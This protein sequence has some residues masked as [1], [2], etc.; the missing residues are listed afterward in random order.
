MRKWVSR[1]FNVI[2][3]SEMLNSKLTDAEANRQGFL[4]TSNEEFLRQYYYADTQ[5]DSIFTV[6]KKLTSSN[7]KQKVLTDSL[8]PLLSLQKEVLHQSI[9]IQNKKPVNQNELVE[10]TNKGK[11]IQSKIKYLI[12]RLQA[13]EKEILEQ[14]NKELESSGKQVIWLQI[15]GTY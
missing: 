15:I 9:D 12:T 14:R 5:S 7:Q 8:S 10:L 4:I 6:I 2:H 3:A 13:E 1:A 11:Q